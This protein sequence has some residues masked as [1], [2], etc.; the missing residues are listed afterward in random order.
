M[1]IKILD[2]EVENLIKD[3]SEISA[4]INTMV[5]K[6]SGSKEA[7]IGLTSAFIIASFKMTLRCFGSE[8]EAKKCLEKMCDDIFKNHKKHDNDYGVS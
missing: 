2:L 4:A 6:A 5:L 1:K 3:F 8:E 7:M